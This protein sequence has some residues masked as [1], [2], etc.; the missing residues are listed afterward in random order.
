MGKNSTSRMH[1]L[2]ET[3]PSRLSRLGHNHPTH[4]N[5]EAQQGSTTISWDPIPQ[6]SKQQENTATD[7]KVSDNGHL[8]T[9]QN[10]PQTSVTLNPTAGSITSKTL[11]VSMMCE[12]ARRL[13]LVISGMALL[14][15]DYYNIENG[16]Q[17]WQY[18][19]HIVPT[20]DILSCN[21]WLN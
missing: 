20:W 6:S 10:A 5:Q 15:V 18:R 16:Q 8:K 12:D 13:T 17:L 19:V 14:A 11:A 21:R 2:P 4:H 7:H 1:V 3:S 9:E